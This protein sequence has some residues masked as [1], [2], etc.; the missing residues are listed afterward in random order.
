MSLCAIGASASAGQQEQAFFAIFAETKTMKMVGMP[1][2]EMPELPPGVK[3]PPGVVLPGQASRT[4]N[5][6]LWSP[7]IAPAGA[8]ASVAPPANLKVGPKMDLELY[9]PSAED[10][11]TGGS[12]AGFDP[13]KMPEFTIKYYWGSSATVR[14][15]QPKVITWGTLTPEQK[16]M[17]KKAAAEAQP[18][19]KGG[20]YFY[21]P[22][23]TTGYWP[24]TKQPGAIEKDATLPGRYDLTTSYTG[25]VSLDVPAGV[26]FLPAIKMTAPDLSEELDFTKPLAFQWSP[27][28]GNLGSY[29]QAMGMVGKNTIIIWSSAENFNEGMMANMDFMQMADVRAKVATKDFMAPNTTAVTIPEGIFKDVD[30]SMLTMTAWGPG[31]ATET[32]QPLPRLQTKSSLQVMLGGKMMKDMGR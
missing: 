19:G 4:I 15:G 25:N 31:A 17:M 7:S 22:D 8:T 11:K 24:T 26:D 5:V 28:T 32:G 23:W 20:I 18:A 14:E 12:A 6:R 1:E 30:F 16:A 10:A 29:A 2:M 3:L 9:R 21:K 13:D 27:V